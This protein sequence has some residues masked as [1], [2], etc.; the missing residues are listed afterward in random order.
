MFGCCNKKTETFV[1]RSKDRKSSKDSD[2]LKHFF[3]QDRATFL[4]EQAAE[5]YLQK[6]FIED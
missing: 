6:Y 2:L 3:M 1:V 4:I 5:Q